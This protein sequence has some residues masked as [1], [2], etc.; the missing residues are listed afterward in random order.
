MIATV[1]VGS[2]TDGEAN[3]KKKWSTWLHLGFPIAQEN[4]NVARFQWATRPICLLKL[5]V[6]RRPSG[7]PLK[8]IKK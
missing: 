8:N 5:L 2:S 1:S 3:S 6:A 7:P 4:A